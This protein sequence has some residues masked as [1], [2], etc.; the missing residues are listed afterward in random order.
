MTVL[1]KHDSGTADFSLS[2]PFPLRLL[3][4]TLKNNRI[5]FGFFPFISRDTLGPDLENSV[6]FFRFLLECN[7]FLLFNNV[8]QLYVYINT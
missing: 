5:H 1:A 6:F 4:F 2:Y 7:C 3:N 8:N